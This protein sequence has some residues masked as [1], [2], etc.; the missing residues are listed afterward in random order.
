[1]EGKVYYAASPDFISD[2]TIKIIAICAG[3]VVVAFF[4]VLELSG[5]RG[6]D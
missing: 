1:M 4:F 2:N 3:L 6:R 5:A